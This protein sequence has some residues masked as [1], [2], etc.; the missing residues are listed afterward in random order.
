MV[1]LEI[2][3]QILESVYPLMYFSTKKEKKDQR[4]RMP[5]LKHGVK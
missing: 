4:K 2:K 3:L 1:F 5:S